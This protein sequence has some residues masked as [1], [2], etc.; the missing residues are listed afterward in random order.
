MNQPQP[1]DRISAV[2]LSHSAKDLTPVVVAKGYG[3]VAE[4]IIRV[5]RDNGLYVHSSP[6]LVRLLMDVDLD[7]RI[8]PQLYVAV[9]ELLAWLHKIEHGKATADYI[10]AINRQDRNAR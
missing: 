1:P 7:A 4:S 8:P 9:A 3:V 6:D 5:A 10:D 2:A